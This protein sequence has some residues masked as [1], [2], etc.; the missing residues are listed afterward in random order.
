VSTPKPSEVAPPAVL[1]SV[2]VCQQG[3]PHLIGD[4]CVCKPR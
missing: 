4:P 2:Y 1:G 3:R